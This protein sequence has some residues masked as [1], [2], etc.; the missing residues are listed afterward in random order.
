[1]S[2]HQLSQDIIL[3]T[4][5]ALRLIVLKSNIMMK[6]QSKSKSICRL[7]Y[8]GDICVCRVS[9]VPF[10]IVLKHVILYSNAGPKSSLSITGRDSYLTEISENLFT[11]ACMFLT[12]CG[13]GMVVQG[14]SLSQ[15]QMCN[16]LA[17]TETSQIAK[18]RACVLRC[19]DNPNLRVTPSE[20]RGSGGWA[21]VHKREKMSLWDKKKKRQADIMQQTKKET[22]LICFNL[23]ITCVKYQHIKLVSCPDD[24]SSFVLSK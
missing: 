1:M 4:K 5:A 22:A 17:T 18:R 24:A 2:V 19:H 21:A 12:R 20:I 6:D 9:L 10:S 3:S 11:P 7:I 16:M 15:Q 23:G 14:S 13:W 8:N